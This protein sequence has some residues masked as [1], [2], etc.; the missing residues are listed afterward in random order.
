[1]VDDAFGSVY[2]R[3]Q[4]IGGSVPITTEDGSAKVQLPGGVPLSIATHVQLDGEDGPQFHHQREAVQFYPGE[5]VRQGFPREL[6]SGFCGGCHGSVSGL[7]SEIAVNPDILT[8]AS[9]VE[10]FSLPPLDLVG[11]RGGPTP[12]PCP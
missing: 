5:W 7:E 1:M 3:R 6:F 2:V 12:P 8:Q 9:S 10:A 4:R 11:E